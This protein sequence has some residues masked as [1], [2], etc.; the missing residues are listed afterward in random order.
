MPDPSNA[1]T[2]D[3]LAIG[4]LTQFPRR[5][6]QRN[7]LRIIALAISWGL[8]TGPAAA[9]ALPDAVAASAESYTESC[10]AIGAKPRP[11]EHFVLVTRFAGEPAYVIETRGDGCM[12]FWGSASC[13]IEIWISRNGAVENV[14]TDNVRGWKFTELGDQLALELALHGSACGRIGAEACEKTLIYRNGRFEVR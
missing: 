9:Q 6:A 8:S 3:D 5:P 10:R 14:F 2:A 1:S 12:S 11:I 7:T 4:T 13:V